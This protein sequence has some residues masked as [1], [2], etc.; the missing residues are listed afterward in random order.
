MTPPWASHTKGLVWPTRTKHWDLT[1]GFRPEYCA[2]YGYPF[3]ENDLETVRNALKGI[4]LHLPSV[5]AHLHRERGR[6]RLY[7][8]RAHDLADRSEPSTSRITSS[9]SD[10]VNLTYRPRP[11]RSASRFS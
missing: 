4:Q 8:D 5:L 3:S 1:W 9:F 2:Q 11:S 7:R 6:R 10:A